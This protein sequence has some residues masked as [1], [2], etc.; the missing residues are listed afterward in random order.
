[1]AALQ[2]APGPE[3]LELSPDPV[4][5]PARFGIRL[6]TG[7]A[8]RRNFRRGFGVHGAV[9]FQVTALAVM[10][11]RI[12]R[13]RIDRRINR[14]INR[15]I[16]RRFIDL[17]AG[18]LQFHLQ[19]RGGLALVLG[20]GDPLE[21]VGGLTRVVFL[22]VVDRPVDVDH[23]R[24]RQHL[25]E[26][27]EHQ[28]IVAPGLIQV[29][30]LA[31]A[32]DA[33]G[34]A[35]GFV[36]IFDIGVDFGRG[37]R[38][39]FIQPRLPP[40]GHRQRRSISCRRGKPGQRFA[41]ADPPE[42]AVRR[43]QRIGLAQQMPDQRFDIRLD[44][45]QVTRRPNLQQ[46]AAQPPIARRESREAIA[47]RLAGACGLGDFE[48]IPLQRIGGH[49]QPPDL[50]QQRGHPEIKVTV[51]RCIRKQRQPCR[52][53]HAVGVAPRTLHRFAFQPEA[54]AEG[55]PVTGIL[56]SGGNQGQR[57]AAPHGAEIDRERIAHAVET[58]LGFGVFRV[59]GRRGRPSVPPPP[60]VFL[61]FVPG[62]QPNACPTSS[63]S[64]A[65]TSGSSLSGS[66]RV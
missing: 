37:R 6:G 33:I 41:A 7:L 40:Q 17:G 48:Q 58:D 45:R 52:Q 16:K 27:V 3:R 61:E 19:L 8:V 2:L 54:L 42:Q 14:R 10:P 4:D 51:Q 21:L 66:I 5:A 50:G 32:P 49:G 34:L 26:R 57:P 24:P 28:R 25:L 55:Q 56:R 65:M 63:S 59:A 43:C 15:R 9:I 38:G 23:L 18:E 35:G 62:G 60:D 44:R 47:E 11:F 29:A 53:H 36:F 31:R 46:C 64:A 20:Q 12:H 1:M 30:A 13:R 22:V 39:G